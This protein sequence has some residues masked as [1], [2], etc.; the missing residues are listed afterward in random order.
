MA[1]PVVHFEVTGKDI[2]KLKDF[3]Q[4][5]FDWEINVMPEMNYG[6]VESPGGGGIGGGIG[7][8]EG[9]GNVMFYIEVEDLVAYLKKIE[10]RGGK[11][12]TPPTEVPNVVTFATFEDPEG[13]L[14]GLVKS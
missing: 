2:Q 9:A 8:T 1:N 11:T 13:H 6:M 7:V 3:Y 5:V 12:V 14:I 10:G 4:G